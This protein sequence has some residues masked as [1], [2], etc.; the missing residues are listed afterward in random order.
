MPF[1]PVLHS[2][3]LVSAIIV[4]HHMQLD[5]ASGTP[6]AMACI[7]LTDDHALG[8]F[9]RGKESR[10]PVVVAIGRGLLYEAEQM[11]QVLNVLCQIDWTANQSGA[12]QRY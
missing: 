6:G 10:R 2:G 7:T 11:L 12:D 3:M 1:E 4:H 9:Q 8:H 5:L